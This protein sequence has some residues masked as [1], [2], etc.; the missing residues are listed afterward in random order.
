MHD[1]ADFPRELFLEII[2]HAIDAKPDQC[3]HCYK[4][5]PKNWCLINKQWYEMIT[6]LIYSRFDFDGCPKRMGAMW[7]FFRAI[8]SRPRLGSYV[9]TL[10]F[11]AQR[12][13]KSLRTAGYASNKTIVEQAIPQAGFDRD[14]ELQEETHLELK[15]G[16]RRPLIALILAHVPGLRR[17]ELHVPESDRF[18]EAVL[19]YAV[20]PAESAPS[21]VAFQSLKTLCLGTAEHIRGIDA[22]Y[23]MPSSPAVVNSARPFGRLPNLEELIMLDTQLDDKVGEAFSA[24]NGITD[25][26]IV[27]H[28]RV[29]P[30]AERKDY[31]VDSLKAILDK[32]TNL[33]HLS[34][35]IPGFSGDTVISMHRK[36]WSALYGLRHK[37]KYLDI[38]MTSV[39]SNDPYYPPTAVLT[40]SESYCPPLAEFTKLRYLCLTPLLLHGNNCKHDPPTK[41]ANHLPPSLE[42]LVLYAVDSYWLAKGAY[43]KDFDV[44]LESIALASTIPLHSIVIDENKYD[45][46]LPSSRVLP[47]RR[48]YGAAEKNEIDINTGSTDQMLFQGGR[49]THSAQKTYSILSPDIWAEWLEDFEP[50]KIIPKGMKVYGFRGTLDDT[51]VWVDEDFNEIKRRRYR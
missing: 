10:S 1:P 14:E 47:T 45:R 5:V 26:T 17:L 16:D 6:P 40:S 30:T 20:G 43:I 13:P 22:R 36:L 31:S 41:L 50:E 28:I 39:Q 49:R 8:V 21:A 27:P 25:L 51:S 38:N 33:T 29:S 44:E 19:K 15:L 18:L 2:Y 24:E 4:T 9:R 23:V 11:T 42:S 3:L 34:L 32:T 37:L 12:L 46:R 7:S 35:A 48:L